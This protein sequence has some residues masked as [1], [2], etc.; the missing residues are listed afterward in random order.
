MQNRVVGSNRVPFIQPLQLMPPAMGIQHVVFQNQNMPKNY[1]RK[2][3]RQS[4]ILGTINAVLSGTMGYLKTSKY[5]NVPQSTLEDR[6]KKARKEQVW[7]KIAKKEWA[8]IKQYFQM[9]KKMSLVEYILLLE[10]RLYS[11]TFKEL[12]S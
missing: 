8:D 1:Q 6:V 7:R 11:L 10:S 3:Q 4:S 2:T 5:Y 12:Q 9:S